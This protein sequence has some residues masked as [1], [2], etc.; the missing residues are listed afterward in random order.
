MTQK[1]SKNWPKLILLYPDKTI[2]KLECVGHIQK[3]MGRN[4]TNL[5]ITCKKKIYYN[6]KGKRVK[7]ISGKNK[8]TKVAIYRIQG[9][10]GAAIHCNVGNKSSTREAIWAIFNHR[11]GDHAKYGQ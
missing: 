2:S 7:G 11:A 3:R 4:L 6:D 8:L 10:Y 1:V 9:Q 5:V